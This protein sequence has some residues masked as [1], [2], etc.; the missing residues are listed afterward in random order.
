MPLR[1]THIL[2]VDDDRDALDEV[3]AVL[4]R[5][6]ATVSAASS[7]QQALS[8]ARPFHAIVADSTCRR[9]TGALVRAFRA[10]AEGGAV[11]AIALTGYADAN[12]VDLAKRAG[13][14]EHLVKPVKPDTLLDTVW[15]WAG[16][17]AVP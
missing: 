4:E 15:L 6:G 1:G 13:F 14:Q 3:R 10:R 16:K 2:V 17:R 12:T 5:A 8:M 7:A 9:W 11:P